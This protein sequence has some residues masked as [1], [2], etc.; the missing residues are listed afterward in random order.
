MIDLPV[1]RESAVEEVPID[2]YAV[3]AALLV[4][5]VR[6]QERVPTKVFTV[7]VVSVVFGLGCQCGGGGGGS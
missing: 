7:V 4:R 6:R 5:A 3:A 2:H 1:A